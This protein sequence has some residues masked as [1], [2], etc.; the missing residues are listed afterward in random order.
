[1]IVIVEILEF[2]LSLHLNY[3]VKDYLKLILST[4]IF[5]GEDS[6]IAKLEE[7]RNLL[8][9]RKYALRVLFFGLVLVELRVEDF[10]L[11]LMKLFIMLFDLADV[12]GDAIHGDSCLIL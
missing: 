8:V 10:L 4:F 1:M 2:K 9:E 5:L 12:G 6:D 11:R 3:G 7:V